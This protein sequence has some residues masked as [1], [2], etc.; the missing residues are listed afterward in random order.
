M[1]SQN[2]VAAQGLIVGAYGR[3]FEVR[4][5]DAQVGRMVLMCSTRGKKGQYVCGDEVAVTPSGDKQGVIEELLPRRTIFHRVDAFKEKLIAANVTQVVMVV[6]T[7]PDF[8]DELIMRC[9]CAVESQS[10]TG[11]IV[12]N[13]CDLTS[14]LQK[15]RALLA[16]F[17]RVGHRVLEINASAGD[18][19]GLRKQLAGQIS[20]LVGQSGMGKTTMLNALVPGTSA[21]TG[22]LSEALHSGKHTTTHARLYELP[23]GGSLIDSPGLQAFGLTQLSRGELEDGF[24]ELRPLRGKCRFRDCQH[25]REPDC[26]FR[27]AVA[28]GEIDARRF[29]VFQALLADHLKKPQY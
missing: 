21:R 4:V 1:I 25:D 20:L 17:A 8:S 9:L 13:K 24:R 10:L 23:G 3:Q 12:L 22:V 14:Q 26:A 29:K 28:A 5:E 16:P 7:E 15:G 18:L 27:A 2:N 6:A 11:L 19:D